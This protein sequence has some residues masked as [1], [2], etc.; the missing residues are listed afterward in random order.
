MP[1]K[2]PPHPGHSIKD[3]CLDPLDLSITEGARLLGVTRQ[4]LTRV[5]HGHCGVSPEMALRLEKIG[6][7]DAD[8]WMGMQLAFDLAR[9]RKKV[10]KLNVKKYQAA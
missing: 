2:S 4:T 10:G 8:E 9:A 1:M 6:W 5:I 3:A 7:G